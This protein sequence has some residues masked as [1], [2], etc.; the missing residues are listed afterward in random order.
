MAPSPITTRSDSNSMKSVFFK[1]MVSRKITRQSPLEASSDSVGWAR[2]RLLR[3]KIVLPEGPGPCP[4]HGT[5]RVRAYIRL[6]GISNVPSL[7]RLT[8]RFVRE[9]QAET[10]IPHTRRFSI[11]VTAARIAV[12]SPDFKP[13]PPLSRLPESSYPLPG[14]AADKVKNLA[15]ARRPTILM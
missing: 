11:N 6:I 3:R 14:P 2:H 1:V 12:D 5:P 7:E 13:F 10:S 15:M 9:P 4:W 8:D